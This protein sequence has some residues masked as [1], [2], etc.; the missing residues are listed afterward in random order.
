MAGILTEREQGFNDGL[1]AAI[2]YLTGPETAVALGIA[3]S[4]V[5]AHRQFV[6]ENRHRPPG[7]SGQDRCRIYDSAGR[8]EHD[9]EKWGTGFRKR[10]CSNKKIERDDDSKK[11]HPAL[12]FATK[13]VA[14]CASPSPAFGGLASTIASMGSRGSTPQRPWL[15]RS[16]RVG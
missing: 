6:C 9:P 4:T 16:R 1:E 7:R 12:G 15:S 8:L 14:A 3:E 11:S 2:D 10:S 13:P 5:K